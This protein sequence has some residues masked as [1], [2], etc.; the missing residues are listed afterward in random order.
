MDVAYL[1]S[2]TGNLIDDRWIP[3]DTTLSDVIRIMADKGIEPDSLSEIGETD[4]HYCATDRGYVSDL[5][6]AFI[7]AAEYGVPEELAMW[8]WERWGDSATWWATLQ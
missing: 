2:F 3:S 8:A 7:E 5:Q 4:Y 1:F 6:R